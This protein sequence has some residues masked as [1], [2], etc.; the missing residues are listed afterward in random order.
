MAADF[1]NKYDDIYDRLAALQAVQ[2]GMVHEQVRLDAASGLPVKSSTATAAFDRV[3]LCPAHIRKQ[4]LACGHTNARNEIRAILRKVAAEDSS[5]VKQVDSFLEEL[6]TLDA[7]ICCL[8]HQKG[9]AEAAAAESLLAEAGAGILS[10]SNSGIISKESQQVRA[11]IAQHA[12]CVEQMADLHDRILIFL[13]LRQ[14]TTLM[15]TE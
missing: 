12:T 1:R 14:P 7:K 9:F 3:E 4:R 11:L 10:S 8:D 13:R 15:P 6:N 5:V 2:C